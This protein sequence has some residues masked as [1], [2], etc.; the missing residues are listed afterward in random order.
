MTCGYDLAE[1]R[2]SAQIKEVV[3]MARESDDTHCMPRVKEVA[4]TSRIIS[5]KRL[6]AGVKVLV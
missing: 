1:S 4:R 6:S 3:L 5:D 2:E